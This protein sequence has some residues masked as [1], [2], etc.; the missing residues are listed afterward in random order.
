MSGQ[1]TAFRRFNKEWDDGSGMDPLCTNTSRTDMAATDCC[2]VLI[3]NSTGGALSRQ[4]FRMGSYKKTYNPITCQFHYEQ[5]LANGE[6]LYFLPV[7]SVWLIGPELDVE[8]GGIAG[9]AAN[10]CPEDLE[11]WQYAGNGWESDSTLKA[12]CME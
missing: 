9:R 1:G 3:F 12:D 4:G 10:V 5:I 11:A 2:E 7:F 8:F 6:F